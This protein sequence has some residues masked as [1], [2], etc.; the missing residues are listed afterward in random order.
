MEICSATLNLIALSVGLSA[1]IVIM[2][3]F[4]ATTKRMPN[5]THGKAVLGGGSD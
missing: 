4:I 2:G 3:L 5:A 1:T